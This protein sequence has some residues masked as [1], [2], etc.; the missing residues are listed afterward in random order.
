MTPEGFREVMGFL[1]SFIQKDKQTEAMVE[2][3]CLRFDNSDAVQVTRARTSA[4]AFT[5]DRKHDP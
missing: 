4:P 2:K 5:H 1:I 3:L